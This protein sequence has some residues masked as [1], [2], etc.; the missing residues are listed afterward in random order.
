VA[1]RL[2]KALLGGLLGMGLAAGPAQAVLMVTALN[3]PALTATDLA[4]ALLAGGGGI[5]VHSATYV[6]AN[7]ASGLFSGGTGIIGFESGILLTSGA[8]GN[9][10]GPNNSGGT[11]AN[12]GPLPGDPDLEGLIPAIQTTQDA[13]VLT[14]VFTPTGGQVTFNYVFGSEEYNEFVNSGFNDVFGFFVNGVN[15]ALIPGTATPVSINNV[16][17]GF[18]VGNNPAPGAGPNCGSYINN[19]NPTFAGLLDTELDGL[20]IVLPITAAVNA[21][22]ENTLKIAISDVND[23]NLD[24]A[25]F[26]QGGSFQVC[27]VAG[28][29]PCPTVPEPG[30]LALLSMG[31]LGL[32]LFRRRR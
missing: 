29:P 21:G 4:N 27:G 11:T 3:P 20:T 7:A 16:N 22:V 23:G 19:V 32:A 2:K 25:V 9:V 31:L 13:S 5:T 30:A 15:A 18:A 8:V 1:L 17:C 14:I 24:S 10:V 28:A 26:I 6:G 12:N